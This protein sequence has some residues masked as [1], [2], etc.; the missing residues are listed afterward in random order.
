MPPGLNP[1]SLSGTCSGW[2]EACHTS[3]RTTTR[4]QD[5][6]VTFTGR[7]TTYSYYL[8]RV[9]AGSL[10]CGD[11][12]RLSTSL[13][14]RRADKPPSKT[15]GEGLKVFGIKGCKGVQMKKGSNVVQRLRMNVQ[16]LWHEEF[17][18]LWQEKCSKALLKDLG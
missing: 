1:G 4:A 16:S 7:A 9:M 6:Q 12:F 15:W 13:G 11:L 10:R 5:M 3:A 18:R 17:K 14:R 8:T 2:A